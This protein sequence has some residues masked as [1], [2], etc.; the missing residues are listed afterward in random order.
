MILS[1]MALSHWKNNF[2]TITQ[3]GEIKVRRAIV[4]EDAINLDMETIEMSNS[5]LNIACSAIY[6]RFLRKNGSYSCQLIFARSKIVPDN[7][8]IPRAELF[9]AVLNA[10]T[11]HVV[12]LSLSKYIKI[13]L[14]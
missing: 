14:V 1:R 10:T 13:V 9:A 8:T 12:H 5:S 4:P 3:F 7:M 2:E 6:G 11:G